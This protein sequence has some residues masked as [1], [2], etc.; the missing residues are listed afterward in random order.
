MDT[1]IRVV[2]GKNK[3][4]ELITSTK[5]INIDD[6]LKIRLKDGELTVK[7]VNIKEN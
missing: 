1:L 2:L 4:D 3:K 5:N 7:V 6:E